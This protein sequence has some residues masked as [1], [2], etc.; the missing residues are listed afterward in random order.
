MPNWLGRASF[1]V[2]DNT[3]RLG[4]CLTSD[5]FHFSGGLLAPGSIILPGNWGRIVKMH[6]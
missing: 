4:A 3:P 6:G 2:G 1:V 5:L